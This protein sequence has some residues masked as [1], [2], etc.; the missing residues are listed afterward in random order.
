[1]PCRVRRRCGPLRCAAVPPKGPPRALRSVVVT[2]LAGLLVAACGGDDGGETT[3]ANLPEGCTEAQAPPSKQV[4]LKPPQQKVGRDEGLVATVETSCGDFE[5]TLDAGQSPKT[6]NSFVYLARQG[7][8]D[9]TIFHRIVPGFVIQGGDPLGTGMGGPGYHVDEPPPRDAEYTMGTVAMAKTATEPP[10]RSGSQ[11]FVV[12][13]ADT[14]L[15]PDYALLGE[16]SSGQSVVERIARLGDPT[17][18][19]GT[20][21]ATVVIRTISVSGG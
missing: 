12:L 9:N 13:P 4:D 8:Y 1:M 10:G 20:P 19:T 18:Q 2:V 5:I 17:S 7:L 6:V 14:G 15:P 16:V 3:S 21:L 11:F